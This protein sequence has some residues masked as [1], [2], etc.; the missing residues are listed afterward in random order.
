MKSVPKQLIYSL[1]TRNIQAIIFYPLYTMFCNS[2]RT[3]RFVLKLR[4]CEKRTETADLFAGNAQHSSVYFYPLYT[5]FC[6]IKQ[7]LR[8][9]YI[10]MPL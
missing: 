3:L 2:K 4:L 6:T 1:R 8:I 5:M 10:I 7:T 9:V